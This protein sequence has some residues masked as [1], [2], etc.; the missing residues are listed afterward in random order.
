[1]EDDFT[2]LDIKKADAKT[3]EILYEDSPAIL[4]LYRAAADENGNPVYKEE[5]LLLTF[6]AATYQDGQAVAATGRY[7]PDSSG[8]RPIMKY[9]YQYQEIPGTKQ[10]RFYYTEQGSV[11]ME[12]LPVG[13]Y[14][15]AEKENP[16]GYA[17]A[18]P[19]F[20]YI[21]DKGHLEEIQYSRMED[22]P[23]RVQVSERR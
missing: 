5:D 15:L 13:Y 14:V 11:R 20:I 16:D 18:D 10:G 7:E 12:Y 3:G 21:E 23:L 2:A 6:R 19:I 1:M 17:T 4:S 8:N 9:D 22:E